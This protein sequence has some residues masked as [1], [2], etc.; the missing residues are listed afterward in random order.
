MDDGT[1]RVFGNTHHNVQLDFF[2]LVFVFYLFLFCLLVK[3]YV[4]FIIPVSLACF[5]A[6]VERTYQG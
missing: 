5:F 2:L 6:V 4:A 1:S 3:P